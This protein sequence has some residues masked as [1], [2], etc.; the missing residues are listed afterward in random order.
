MQSKFNGDLLESDMVSKFLDKEIYPHIF[1][2]GVNRC[3]DL[4]SQYAGVD[5]TACYN[6]RI[7]NVDEKAQINY[8]NMMLP[9][10]VLEV[11]HLSKDFNSRGRQS[12]KKG[13]FVNN[14][15]ETEVYTFI[16]FPRVNGVKNRWDRLKKVEQLQEVEVF[17]VPKMDLV[18]HVENL[19][20]LTTMELLSLSRGLW[21]SKNS[22]VTLDSVSGTK[23][24]VSRQLQE[25]PINIVLHKKFFPECTRKIT[26]V[27]SKGI[28]KDT[29]V[30]T[31]N[32]HT[33][34]TMSTRHNANN[35]NNANNTPTVN[36]EHNREHVN[37][38]QHVNNGD[39]ENTG[40]GKQN[41]DEAQQER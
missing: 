6:G 41:A 10:Q 18:A 15:L 31:N 12:R 17:I 19:T 33:G 8:K 23:L 11:A 36:N 32:A 34:H 40:W 29:G 39:N 7:V 27:R 5:F 35:A 1:S 20:G 28:I 13:W 25:Q 16:F 37:N 3:E 4:A 9:T 26:W 24:M 14:K 21:E 22:K 30:D 38:S 2:G